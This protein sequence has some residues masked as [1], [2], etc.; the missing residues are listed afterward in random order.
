MWLSYYD[1]PVQFVKRKFSNCSRASKSFKSENRKKNV[2]QW[3]KKVNDFIISL[4]FRF[5]KPRFP[6]SILEFQAKTKSVLPY[7]IV[8]TFIEFS[9][10]FKKPIIVRRI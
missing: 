7:W 2:S 1:L 6:L 9:V 4:L 3:N 8:C 10:E 5:K